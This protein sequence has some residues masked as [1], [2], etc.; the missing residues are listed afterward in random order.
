MTVVYEGANYYM[1]RKHYTLEFEADNR[2][3]GHFGNA[4]CD[5]ESN[6]V[7][8]YDQDHCDASRKRWGTNPAPRMA[9]LT[10]CRKCAK[11]AEKRGLEVS[12]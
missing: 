7:Q 2:Q 12:R 11:Q 6:P 1:T 9:D 10:L 8:I 3:T 5:S 4:L